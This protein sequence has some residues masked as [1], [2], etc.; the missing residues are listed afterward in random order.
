MCND[1]TYVEEFSLSRLPHKKGPFVKCHCT[2][3]KFSSSFNILQ[4]TFPLLCG[5]D[6]RE[7][8]SGARLK[9]CEGKVDV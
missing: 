6:E 5:R 8:F 7:S 1:F 4:F 9:L 2:T 3:G